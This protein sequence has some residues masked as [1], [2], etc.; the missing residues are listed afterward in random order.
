[1]QASNR[2]VVSNMILGIQGDDGG[3]VRG[4]GGKGRWHVFG[5]QFRVGGKKWLARQ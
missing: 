2:K 1:M 5:K 3:C 4:G